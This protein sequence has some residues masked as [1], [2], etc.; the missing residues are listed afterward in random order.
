M[1]KTCQNC[2]SFDPQRFKNDIRTSHCGLCDKF[3]EVVFKSDNGCKY[4][5]SKMN[6]PILPIVQENKQLKLF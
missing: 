6:P 3:T 5:F 2:I 1:T 4:F